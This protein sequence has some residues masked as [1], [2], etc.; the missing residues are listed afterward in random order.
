MS[1]AKRVLSILAHPDDAE[2]LCTGTMIRLQD[3]GWEIHIASM[4]PG[5]CGSRELEPEKIAAVRM[6]E[7]AT[8]AAKIRGRY[9]CLDGR[10]LL[11]CYDAA[12]IRR[13]VEL[14][15]E[16]DPAVVITHSP[17]D[18][19]VDHEMTAQLARTACFGAPAPNFKTGAMPCAPATEH[20]PHLYYAAPIEGKNIFGEEA[21]LAMAIDISEVIGLKSDML[22]CHK[23]QRE[24]L[25]AQHGMDEYIEAMRRWS[26]AVGRRIGVEYAEG[27]RQ[28]LGHAYP[29]DD[30][31]G[32]LLGGRKC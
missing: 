2:F 3:Q 11:V 7:A 25:R 8:A 12:A 28:H 17:D 30:L 13:T 1:T 32:Q 16:V 22:A 26:G 9:H 21:P 23:S 10:D 19:M 18:Y 31:L 15:R 4:T 14:V 5:D 24:W 29:Q 6:E 27:F 20:I